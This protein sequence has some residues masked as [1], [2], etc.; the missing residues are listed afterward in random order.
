MIA[1]PLAWIVPAEVCA[2]SAAA[3]S[4]NK[5]T[6]RSGRTWD[7]AFLLSQIYPESERNRFLPVAAP[8]RDVTFLSPEPGRGGG[9]AGVATCPAPATVQSET[10][11]QTVS[12]TAVDLAGNRAAAGVTG[13]MD[14]TPPAVTITSPADGTVPR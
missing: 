3:D 12:G 1:L 5:G 11:G 13:Q 9:G 7:M 6:N 8:G 4:I 14:K 10:A 2:N